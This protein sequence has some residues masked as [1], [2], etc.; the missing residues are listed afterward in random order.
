MLI[1][2]LSPGE[3]PKSDDILH[4]FLT[5]GH[6]SV[7]DLVYAAERLTLL[8]TKDNKAKL[9][10]LRVLGYLVLLAPGPDHKALAEI[11]TAVRTT[12]LSDLYVLGEIYSDCFVRSCELY[13]NI[14]GTLTDIL[15]VYKVKGSQTPF[16]PSH[17]SRPSF[18]A[19]VQEI[20][21]TI[22]QA[23]K[24]HSEAK[25]KAL[26]RDGY[27]CVVTGTIDT[28]CK[29]FF[30]LTELK[31]SGTLRTE[32][33]HIIPEATYFGLDKGKT[34]CHYS[35]SV[36]AVFDRFGVQFDKLNEGNIHSLWNVMTL[37]QPIHDSFDRLELWF[38]AT[39]SILLYALTVFSSFHEYFIKTTDETNRLLSEL[40]GPITL[41][42]SDPNVPLPDPKLLAFHAAACRVAYLSGAT[43]YMEEILRDFERLNVLAE[44]G[45]SLA[46]L[47]HAFFQA[48]LVR[49]EV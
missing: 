28:E 26:V 44:D 24:N 41:T 8:T 38:E 12:D 46:I 15:L 19:R 39:V 47:E 16:T 42:S 7:Y 43:E 27:R 3:L 2:G 20:K 23:P 33:A 4:F 49:V 31:K 34:V 37:V 45:G 40:N 18:D 17:P 10:S 48:G 14:Q 25:D 9:V 13:R 6:K 22:L 5:P 32:C 36:L 35:A 1:Q 21:A 29:G 11:A 30:D